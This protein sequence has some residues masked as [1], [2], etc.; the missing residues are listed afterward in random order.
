MAKARQTR[1]FKGGAFFSLLLH[2]C[3]VAFMVWQIK[4]PFVK[5][6]E[7]KVVQVA[8]VP[9]EPPKPVP[10][11]PPSPK[12]PKPDPPKPDPPKP[13]PPKPDP[14]KP[15]PPEKPKDPPKPKPP[16][17]PKDPPKPKPPE[18]PKEQPKPPEKTKEQS[19]KDRFNN[20]T[21]KE[22]KQPPSKTQPKNTKSVSERIKEVTGNPTTS[23]TAT[24]NAKIAQEQ[25]NYASQIVRPYVYD[26]WNQPSQGELDV[27]Q[28]QPV[29]ISFTVFANGTVTSK[30]IDKPSNSQAINRTIQEFLNNLTTLPPPS[31]IGSNA[32][33]LHIVVNVALQ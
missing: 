9:I 23:P 8:L 33:S 19:I 15:K 17:K 13:D 22:T 4:H 28:P 2:A 32:S 21:V 29:V 16:E 25:A 31:R 5:L 6:P 18:K 11:Q 1:S 7:P 24:S 30:R 20:A 12:P 3:L 27:R 26:H 14:P 10:P